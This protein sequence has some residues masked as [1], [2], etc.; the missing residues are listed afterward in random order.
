MS[1][2]EP[3]SFVFNLRC[4]F[5]CEGQEKNQ[6]FECHSVILIFYFE[7]V[8]TVWYSLFILVADLYSFEYRRC[9]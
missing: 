2:R 3:L 6:S 9:R 5:D 1:S 4:R 7:I 8:P